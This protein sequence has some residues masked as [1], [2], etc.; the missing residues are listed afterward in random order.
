MGKSFNH[1][2]PKKEAKDGEVQK[3]KRL[4]RRL[5]QENRHLKSQLRTYEKAYEKTVVFLQQKTSDFDLEELIDGAN[6]D[7]NI[8]EIRQ[9]KKLKFEDLKAKWKCFK[10]NEGVMRL[11]II[12]DNRYFRK[13]STCTHRTE[14]K[15]YE[16]LPEGITEA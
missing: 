11:I 7:L 9:E 4:I 14:T 16:E 10:C 15:E 8:K 1:K 2:E 3:L 6:N 13:C 12:P 5:E